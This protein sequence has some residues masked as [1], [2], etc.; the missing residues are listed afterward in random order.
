[1]IIKKLVLHNFGIY[2]GTN[3]FTFDG[4]KNVVLIGGMNG[5]GKTTILEAVLLALYG[6]NSFA[7]T[8]SK[9]QSYSRYLDSYVNRADGTCQAYVTLDFE[10]DGSRYIVKRSWE[11]NKRRINDIIE[12]WQ[13]DKTNEFLTENWVMFIENLLPSGL[14]NF[15][16]FDGEKIA[17]LA[18][19][20]TDE[21]LKESIKALL[22]I[23]VLESL[24]RN[25]EK[26]MQKSGKEKNK[27]YKEEVS[28]ELKKAKEGAEQRLRDLD[29]KIHRLEDELVVA[30][31]KIEQARIEYISKGGDI[32]EKKE[33]YYKK[34]SE[35]AAKQS[36]QKEQLL[37]TAASELP[38]VLVRDLLEEMKRSVKKERE[39]RENNV[40]LKRIQEFYSSYKLDSNSGDL[41]D[42]I[43]YMTDMTNKSDKDMVYN[44]S[45]ASW[46]QLV[47][48]CEG[49]LDRRIV[50]TNH[51]FELCNDT[52]QEIES[53]DSLLSV[54]IDEEKI[55]KIY[56]KIIKL[57]HD[58]SKKEVELDEYKRERPH[59]NN[60]QIKANTEFSRYVEGMLKKLETSDDY[61][62]IVKYSHLA[63]SVL[64]EYKVKLQEKKIGKLAD[65]M[66]QCY[67]QLAN[68]KG[69]IVRIEMDPVSLD[70][71]Y[72]NDKKEEIPKERLSAG[73]KQLMVVSLL[74]ALANCS[75]RK[76]PVIIDTPLSRLDSKHRMALIKTYFPNASDQTIILSTDSE[77]Y[78]KYYSALKKNVGNEYTLNYNDETMSTTIQTGYRWEDEQ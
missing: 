73:E 70:L 6:R 9:F 22:G 77:I 46:L 28:Y 34:R 17:E 48:L 4:N 32:F 41:D 72:L 13:D 20:S 27:V 33:E 63:T 26:L 8:E 15:F 38:L 40:A 58:K 30:D 29:N 31:K 44:L 53:T 43:Q 35:L 5:R 21:K 36:Q 2:A 25:L 64:S 71:K 65:A 11:G 1:M 23:E 7:Y 19:D 57:E 76:L 12:V 56:K 59:I 50:D 61:G 69:M 42:F 52:Q 62:R 49:K 74:W 10:M 51:L 16:F 55:G 78:G 39:A 37:D 75:S 67:K 18:A 14:S 47:Q 68:K 60:A 66:T 24:D 54:E 45:D 3:K